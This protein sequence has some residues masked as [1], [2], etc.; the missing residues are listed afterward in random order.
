MCHSSARAPALQQELGQSRQWAQ[1]SAGDTGRGARGSPLP[2]WARMGSARCQLTEQAEEC[3]GTERAQQSQEPCS[4]WGPLSV[5]RGTGR[6]HCPPRADKGMLRVA[7]GHCQLLQPHH[8]GTISTP[9]CLYSWW[10]DAR[11]RDSCS[12]TPSASRV[13]PQGSL[14]PPKEGGQPRLCPIPREH[15][16]F[17]LARH[18]RRQRQECGGC[19]NNAGTLRWWPP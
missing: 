19:R 2:G 9:Q 6:T 1:G 5:P 8:L 10:A 16:A 12:C 3:W 4:P 7:V 11:V 14:C 13:P 17:A 18:F 15:Q